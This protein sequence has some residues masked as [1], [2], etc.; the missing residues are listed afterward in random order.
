[1]TGV[2]TS[3]TGRDVGLSPAIRSTADIDRSLF[4]VPDL[5]LLPRA[6]ARRFLERQKPQVGRRVETGAQPPHAKRGRAG[7]PDAAGILTWINRLTLEYGSLYVDPGL[8][9]RVP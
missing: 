7:R 3:Q 2:G 9:W 5:H 6:V 1:M 4:T 8:L